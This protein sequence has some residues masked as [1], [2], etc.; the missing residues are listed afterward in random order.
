MHPRASAR[1]YHRFDVAS[2]RRP[3]GRGGPRRIRQPIVGLTGSCRVRRC[4]SGPVSPPWRDWAPRLSAPR[5]LPHRWAARPTLGGRRDGA[6][7][8]IHSP[9]SANRPGRVLRGSGR[10]PRD[11]DLR[12]GGDSPQMRGGGA[13]RCVG[14]RAGQRRTLGPY[15]RRAGPVTEHAVSPLTGTGSH[16]A[17]PSAAGPRDTSAR[18]CRRCGGE[19]QLIGSFYW[20]VTARSRCPVTCW[21]AGSVDRSDPNDGTD[22]AAGGEAPR[23]PD[24]ARDL[25]GDPTGR[26][27]GVHDMPKRG[28]N[29][30]GYP[31]KPP[32]PNKGPKRK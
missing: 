13:G 14:A 22:R 27:E 29:K 32:M 12:V 30:V 17:A 3:S 6:R 16:G 8:R 9:V 26:T 19:L 21:P 20:H 1:L 2:R 7:S 5:R 4:Y 15:R 18:R 31:S 23:R 11:V 24:L 28:G 25:T 10:R